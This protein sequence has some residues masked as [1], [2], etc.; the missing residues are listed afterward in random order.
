MTN[1]ILDFALESSAS[2]P[3]YFSTIRHCYQSAVESLLDHQARQA[4]PGIDPHILRKFVENYGLSGFICRY[5]NCARATDGFDSS[6]QRDAHEATHQRKFRCA[7]PSCVS[8]S[9]G[10]ATRSAL[11]KHN[12]R[13]HSSIDSNVSLLDCI[14][15]ALENSKQPKADKPDGSV[16]FDADSVELD[17]ISKQPANG[18]ESI[19]SYAGVQMTATSAGTPPAGVYGTQIPNDGAALIKQFR[20]DAKHTIQNNGLFQ[21]TLDLEDLLAT[22]RSFNVDIPEVNALDKMIQQI[23]WNDRARNSRGQVLTFKDVSDIIE[24]GVKL[25]IPSDNEFLDHYN[26]KRD[27]GMAWEA[28][29]Q[30]L[31]NAE[32][33]HY[34]QLEALSNQAQAAALPVYAETLAAID[35]ILNKKREAHRQII[36]LYERSKDEDFTKRPKYSEVREAMEHLIELNGGPKPNGTLD[37]EKEQKRHEDWMRKGKKLF[38]KAGA[39]LHILKSHMEYV[40]ECNISC[41]DIN[42]DKPRLPAKPASRE[43]SPLDTGLHSWEDPRFRELFCI[44]RRIEAGMMIECGLCHEW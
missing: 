5:I 41:F 20:L 16:S 40:L 34:P 14:T 12:D 4:F 31:I 38:G 15:S 29:A 33:V 11:N 2:D 43:P 18:N 9:S 1:Q 25:E 24:D 8:F 10:F 42:D 39:P 3:T 27:A 22:G 35:Q 19:G 7:H 36:S 23:K 44:C 13:Y 28:K 21:T 26:E 37:L 32:F 17:S 30:E 6:K